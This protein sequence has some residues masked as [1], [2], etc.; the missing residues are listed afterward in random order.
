MFYL[1]GVVLISNSKKLWDYYDTC[2]FYSINSILDELLSNL[3]EASV[4]SSDFDD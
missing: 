1:V 4:L 2:Y 3:S